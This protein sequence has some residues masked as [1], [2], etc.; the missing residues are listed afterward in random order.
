MDRPEKILAQLLD[1]SDKEAL[2]SISIRQRNELQPGWQENEA[3]KQ[4][5]EALLKRIHVLGSVRQLPLVLRK[6]SAR[7]KR[8]VYL[9]CISQN[10][11]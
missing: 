7:R 2:I 10:L 11:I 6:T 1:D 8:P 9:I 3:L 4:E 5:R